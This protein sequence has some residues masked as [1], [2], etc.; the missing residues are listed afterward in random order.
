M[1]ERG[2]D[3]SLLDLAF[4]DGPEASFLC[5]YDTHTLRPGVLR[6]AAE[7]HPL[8]DD[9]GTQ[10]ES[11][12]YVEPQEAGAPF[13]GPLPDPPAQA[14]ELPF[15]SPDDL[16]SRRAGSWPTV[17]LRTRSTPEGQRA[18]SSPSTS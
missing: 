14:D 4:A 5:A 2:H 1:V 16:G 6:A 13:D 12:L 3:E 11:S 7:S 9:H 17:T 10:R 18:P 15:D 8:I